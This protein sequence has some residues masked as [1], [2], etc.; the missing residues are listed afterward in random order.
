MTGEIA[1]NLVHGHTVIHLV[2]AR[3]T[4]TTRT[5]R[6][7]MLIRLFF[8]LFKWNGGAIG[9]EEVHDKRAAYIFPIL[10]SVYAHY[11]ITI[12]VLQRL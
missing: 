4:E 10:R 9:S 12:A 2:D 5:D 7:L 1:G 8:H 6:D 3:I 11:R